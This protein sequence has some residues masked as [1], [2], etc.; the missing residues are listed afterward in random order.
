MTEPSY[1]DTTRLAYDGLAVRY[2]E[3]MRGAGLV[4][5]ARL[6]REPGESERFRQAHL[7]ARK[8]AQPQR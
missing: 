7:L 6:V 4:E 1:L 3:L 2:A 8:P 5:V